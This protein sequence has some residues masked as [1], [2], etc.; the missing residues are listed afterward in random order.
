MK[1]EKNLTLHLKQFLILTIISLSFSKIK[2]PIACTNISNDKNLKIT[3]DKS[4]NDLKNI[5]KNQNK[6][7][8]RNRNDY[9]K[10]ANNGE[11]TKKLLYEELGD[12][13]TKKKNFE[14]EEMNEIYNNF[15]MENRLDEDVEYEKM[16][17]FNPFYNP[18]INKY[19]YE[20]KESKKDRLE[21]DVISEQYFI[22]KHQN[23]PTIDGFEY[24][25]EDSKLN[26]ILDKDVNEE[27]EKNFKK[28]YPD[29]YKPKQKV[30]TNKS[31]NNLSVNKSF[32]ENPLKNKLNKIKS[33]KDISGNILGK[34]N[35]LKLNN[36]VKMTGFNR[37]EKEEDSLMKVMNKNKKL[38]PSKIK[39]LHIEDYS[40]FENKP[41]PT[42]K[43]IEHNLEN[44]INLNK[45][46]NGNLFK[47]KFKKTM[48]S[49]NIYENNLSKRN[50]L[51]L[52][53][54]VKINKFVE[55]DKKHLTNILNKNKNIE[56]SKLNRFKFKK[57]D[58]E[59]YS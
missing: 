16:Y 45:S 42:Q 5:Y 17:L 6:I 33:S 4:N 44:K 10:I 37:K 20:N 32:N 50:E 56:N 39:N 51:P 40:A 35:K 1:K 30:S 52:K 7:Y 22:L 54:N 2:A 27:F 43:A 59:K 24:E 29:F 3:D 48:S 11:Y 15:L 8:G 49:K 9:D 14:I 41:K 19:N 36:S 13:V 28:E 34:Q 58:I 18:T 26:K 31:K 38:N 12:F 55:K 23:N 57:P 53:T 25:N 47:N 46:F 21:K